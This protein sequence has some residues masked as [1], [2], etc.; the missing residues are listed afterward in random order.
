M[1]HE[2]KE[3]MQNI[4]RFK[5]LILPAFMLLMMAGLKAN[6]QKVI[7]LQQAVDS[8]IKNN[9][10]IKQAQLTEALADQDYQQAK[11]NE[12]PS[13]S[14]NPQGGYYFGKSQVADQLAYSTQALNINA[15]AALSLT[16]FQGKQL[17]N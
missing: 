16:L 8:T 12:L 1:N 5:L 6:A 9:L 4:S 11:Y 3:M 2:P 15:Q 13:L 17:H 14:A 10:T 7:S